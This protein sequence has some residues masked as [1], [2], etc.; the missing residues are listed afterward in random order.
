M[1]SKIRIKNF[2]Q[3]EDQTIEFTSA[4]VIVGPNN[5]GKTTV[6]QAISLFAIAVTNWATERTN[7]R[8]SKRTGVAISIEDLLN[9]PV[10][11]VNQMWRGMAVREGI[12]NEEGKPTAKNIRIEIHAEGLTKNIPWRVGFEFDYGRDTLIYARLTTDPQTNKLYDFPE[13]LIQERIGYLPSISGLSSVEDKLGKGSI[14]RLI[15]QGKT[16]DVLRNVCLFLYEDEDKSRWKKF[17][18][19][20]EQ[21]FKI[22]LNAPQHNIVN[23]TLSMTYNE[24]GKKSM[25][26]ASLGSGAKQTV[27][28]FSYLMAFP[29]SVHLL[30]EPDAHLEVIRQSNIYDKISD[31]AKSNDTQ[32]I[33]AS[34]SESVLE[35][36]F[37]RDTV[38]SAVFGEFE[39]INNKKY[40]KSTL[41]TIG[42]EQ[43]LISKQKPR[44]LYV[45]GT[46][47]FD[48]LKAFAKKI[49]RIDI[50]DFLENEVCVHPV[51]NDINAVRQHFTT[52]KEF[53]PFLTGFAVFDNL[54]KEIANEIKGLSFCQ[55]SKNEVEN[56]LPLP[57]SIQNYVDLI[58][59]NGPLFN[60]K[61]LPTFQKIITANTIPAALN[62]IDHSFWKNTKISDDY[63]TP[64]F[65]QFFKEIGFPRGTMDKSKYYKLVD[66]C[67]ISDIDQEVSML[68]NDIYEHFNQT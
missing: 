47:D 45:E 46:T 37:S 20:I 27:L 8:A 3:I 56:Y 1:I 33:I 16:A 64:I 11:E 40:L 44:I 28:L 50:A 62:D 42:Y 57:L 43:L 66:Y 7:S 61:Y 10:T 12:K 15:G 23:G 2:R 22:T 58:S 48:F 24:L 65:E 29:N 32:I 54:R 18:E 30:D 36:A 34:H 52:L 68:L 53:I 49:N 60:G 4:V 14:F 17:V 63:L 55:W 25:D 19:Q 67:D 31:I 35:R 26:I 5:G 39:V 51:A 59:G 6:L 13:I 9:I 21:I 41:T 38:I